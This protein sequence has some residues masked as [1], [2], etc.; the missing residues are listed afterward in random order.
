[1]NLKNV[2]EERRLC[3]VAIT[4]AEDRLYISY[5]ANRFMYGQES[6][7]TPSKFIDEI[8]ENL[9]NVIKNTLEIKR[10]K[11]KIRSVTI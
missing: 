2:E 7:R 8:P 1:M 6:F 11:A 10:E 5:A 3:Y 4:R 9:L